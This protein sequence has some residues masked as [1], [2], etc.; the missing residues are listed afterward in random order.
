L[1]GQTGPVVKNDNQKRKAITML[2]DIIK[3]FKRCGPPAA[4]HILALKTAAI[5]LALLCGSALADDSSTIDADCFTFKTEQPLD[6]PAND[7]HLTI[8]GL[9]I[10]DP[11]TD[12]MPNRNGIDVKTNGDGTIT[13]TAHFKGGAVANGHKLCVKFKSS[14]RT[15]NPS[16]QFTKDGNPVGDVVK[17]LAVDDSSVSY[18]PTPSGGFYANLTLRN[19][20]G[21]P[22]TG[23]VQV[24]VNSGHDEHYNLDEYDTL[25][26]PRLVLSQPNF[27]LQP[28]QGFTNLG[29]FLASSD[30]Y[31]LI[32]GVADAS[33]GSG[34]SPFAIAIS[35]VDEAHL[36]VIRPGFS[37]IANNFNVGG[38]SLDEVLPI[39]DDGTL[40]YKYDS[41]GSNYSTYNYSS[42]F[43]WEPPGGTLAPGEGAF[44]YTSVTTQF[45]TFTG[46]I[47]AA[48]QRPRLPAGRYLVSCP[49]PQPCSFETLM[50]FPPVIGDKVYRYDGTI[51]NLNDAPSSVHT[52]GANGWNDVP[53]LMPGKSAFVILVTPPP[54]T[55]PLTSTGALGPF[56]PS[57]NV[58]FNTT[59]GTFQMGT[60]TVSGARTAMVYAAHSPVPFRVFDF[61][62]INIPPGITV[63]AVGSLPLVLLAQNQASINGTIDVS[64]TAGGNSG[65]WG[66]GGG[67]GGGGAV[68][69]FANN[70]VSVGPSGQILAR[71]GFGGV[72]LP[73]G[74]CFAA[75]PGGLAGPGGGPG[76]AGGASVAGGAGGNGGAAALGLGGWI[77]LGEGGGGG[78]GG[79]YGGP[80]GLGGPGLVNGNPGGPGAGGA[81]PAAVNGGPGGSGGSLP[82]GLAI[83]GA[84]GPG[85]IA[86]GGGGFPGIG[87]AVNAGGGGGG[88]GAT[89]G[90]PGAPGG[91][92]AGWG[93]GG[94]GGGGADTCPGA[95][96][97]PAIGGPGGPGGGGGGVGFPGAP[98]VII[99]LPS[100]L[101]LGGA[102]GGGCIALGARFGQIQNAGF[103]S[104]LGGQGPSSQ[105]GFGNVVTYG[106]MQNNGQIM[107]MIQPS[108]GQTASQWIIGGGGGGGGAGGDGQPNMRLNLERNASLL[109]ISWDGGGTLET[110]NQITGPW[111]PMPGATSPFTVSTGS[112]SQFFRLSSPCP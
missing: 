53:V 37:A 104:V 11:T 42:A 26:N 57:Q 21:V 43:G 90:G 95:F 50:G 91:P 88:G 22:L 75:G 80:G 94:G 6:S 39:V 79:A 109:V 73:G 46:E 105:G 31:L 99:P 38:N 41:F 108:W 55:L 76:S 84:G 27:A 111:I 81:C 34:G 64:G 63:R 106:S 56:N 54:V 71:G 69:I 12:A 47:P 59:A 30:D 102:G 61:S 86:P 92:G 98:G 7:F 51:T 74:D 3:R 70:Y 96:G 24:L 23:S 82:F 25:R 83:G 66:G 8:N 68:A 93:G 72:S 85:G 29:A 45:L 112:G 33:D 52:F 100:P 60:T 17:S 44:I 107:G 36:C 35:P 58:V 89:I 14:D 62:D 15:P 9:F 87:G 40:L 77:F 49:M 1:K 110:A 32:Q 19:G 65:R 20:Y 13:S 10:G 5:G 78:G 2:I 16:G 67:G 18:M 4:R 28:G 103:L 101:K 48:S 97:A